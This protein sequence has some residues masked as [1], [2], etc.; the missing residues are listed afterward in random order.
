MWVFIYQP[1]S[2]LYSFFSASLQYLHMLLDL[3]LKQFFSLICYEKSKL[4][5][6]N[7][8][9]FPIFFT[10]SNKPSVVFIF[11]HSL[12]SLT[13]LPVVPLSWNIDG[14][15]FLKFLASSTDD[16]RTSVRWGCNSFAMT[17]VD[18]SKKKTPVVW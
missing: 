8:T 18:W 1:L 7:K 3:A 11:F 9:V 13:P 15:C 5:F 12:L 4:W 17:G 14:N 6:L 16:Q 10:I 2:L